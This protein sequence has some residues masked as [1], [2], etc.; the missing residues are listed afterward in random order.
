MVAV[1]KFF[2]GFL[3]ILLAVTFVCCVYGY[4]S[5]TRFSFEKWLTNVSNSFSEFDSLFEE[6][7]DI[8]TSDEYYVERR[9]VSG[10]ISTYADAGGGENSGAIEGG[11]A[12]D[13]ERTNFFEKVVG[14][15]E[16]LIDVFLNLD[17]YVAE[18]IVFFRRVWDTILVVVDI[19]VQIVDVLGAMLPWNAV[20]GV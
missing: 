11:T 20:V 18:I 2:N 1:T 5:N 15:F 19:I 6:I 9:S 12:A 8:W 16:D 3:A 7:A 4:G 13:T 14:F 10:E 17:D